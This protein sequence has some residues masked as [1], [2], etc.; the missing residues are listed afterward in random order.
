MSNIEKVG[1][2]LLHVLLVNKSESPHDQHRL[3]LRN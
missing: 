1:I 3:V 2:M